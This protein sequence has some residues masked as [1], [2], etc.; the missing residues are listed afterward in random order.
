MLQGRQNRLALDG[1]HVLAHRQRN[2][3]TIAGFGLLRRPGR[4]VR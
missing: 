1:R 4:E 2:H 3:R